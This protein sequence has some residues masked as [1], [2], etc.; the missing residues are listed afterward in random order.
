MIVTLLLPYPIWADDYQTNGFD[1]SPYLNF[2]VLDQDFVDRAVASIDDLTRR[3]YGSGLRQQKSHDIRLIQRLLDEEKIA[4]N[5]H[6][7]LQAAGFAL[8]AMMAEELDLT[9]IRYRDEK[10]VSRAL[11]ARRTD[12]VFFP[13]SMIARRYSVGLMPDVAKLHQEVDQIVNKIRA[14]DYEPPR[15]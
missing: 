5:D 13:A 11:H 14:L 4:A 9:W 8:G 2:R 15:Y 7:M 6:A 10:G 12:S 3:Y 1:D